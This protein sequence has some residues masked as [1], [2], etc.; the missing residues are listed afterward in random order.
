MAENLVV[1]RIVGKKK[2]VL[3][4]EPVMRLP[5]EKKPCR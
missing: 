2:D 5:K 1:L 3:V 4:I